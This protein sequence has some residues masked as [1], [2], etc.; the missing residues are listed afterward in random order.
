MP[1]VNVQGN[2]VFYHQN[3]D[4]QP[5]RPTLLFVHGAGGTGENW[6]NQLSG[7][8]G[9]NLIA[10]DLPGHG[11]SNGSAADTIIAYREFIWE[12]AKALDLESFTI[13]GHSMGGAI[14]MEL[15][16]AYPNALQGQIIVGSGARLKVNPK[17]LEK[18]SM[19][20]HPLEI[21]KYSYSL[22]TSKEILEKANEEMKT[23]PTEVYL[24]DFRACNNFNLMERVKEINVPTLIICGQDDQMTPVK[25]SEHLSQ[26]LSASTVVLISNAGHMSM[27]EQP[28]QVNK[29]IQDFMSELTRD[30]ISSRSLSIE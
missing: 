8:K 25:Y 24:A 1:F 22:S 18:L 23:V 12:V 4:Y 9:Y 5:N 27:I 28:Q 11:L 30:S 16:L 14:A 3:G 17:M 19:N 15:A 7:I 21:V 13:V 10:P 6:H 26:E 29:A 2:S 20:I